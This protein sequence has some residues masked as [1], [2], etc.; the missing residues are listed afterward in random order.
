MSTR[1]IE[2]ATGPVDADKLGFTL[3]HEHV[4][5]SAGGL[6]ESFPFLFDYDRTRARIIQELKEAKAG[7]IDT[8]IELTTV[9]LGRDAELYAEASRAGG[10]NVIVTT[11]FWLTIPLIF[12]DR[13]PDF[14]ARMFIHEI[15]HGIADTGIRPGVI[16]A[17]SDVEGVTPEA[18]AVL[19]GAARAHRATGVPISTHQAAGERVG[20]RQVDILKNEGVDLSR[21]CIGHSA[22]T[23]DIDYLTALL[24]QGVFLSMDRYPGREGR[25]DWQTRNATVKALVDRGFS[26]QLMLGHDYAPSPA[27]AGEEPTDSGPTTYLFL[28]RTAIPAMRRDGV[29]EDAIRAMTVESPRRFLSGR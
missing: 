13:D 28:S 3:G 23:T 1:Q 17:S 12:K 21:V 4:L 2:T 14:F 16:K 15:E 24:E 8:I 5:I 26:G 6:K 20:A 10:V 9:D 22:D 19:R 11:G 27:F 25:P 18:E 29:S 7:G